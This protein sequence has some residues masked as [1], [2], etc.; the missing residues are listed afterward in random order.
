MDGQPEHVERFRDRRE[1]GAVL[2]SHLRD[3]GWSGEA[4][5]LA[6]PRGGV[7]VAFE[8]A[9]ALHLP[10]DLFVV[11]KIGL[12]RHPELAMGAVAS[13]D[14]RTANDAVITYYGISS[15][16]FEEAARRETAEI[17]RR[18]R[19]YRGSRAPLQVRD[20]TVFLVDDGLAT[21]AT[22]RAAIAAVRQLEPRRIVVA[23]PV[24]SAEACTRLGEIADEVICARI[25]EPFSAV[26]DWYLDFAQTSDDEVRELLASAEK[27]EER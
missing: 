1:A 24:G 22:M 18:E 26:G 21:G 20:R 10:L 8:V 6:L 17:D 14:V 9:K 16:T 12:P 11:R 4:I 23:V 19:A 5:V 15:D 25:P 7:P 3:H 2:A 13:G 27:K